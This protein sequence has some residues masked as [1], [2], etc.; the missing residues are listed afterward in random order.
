[1]V[2]RVRTKKTEW[3][4]LSK[5]EQD[6][7]AEEYIARVISGKPSRAAYLRIAKLKGLKPVPNPDRRAR[8]STAK[9]R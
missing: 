3:D 1:M 7:L 5:R 2:T 6:R 9:K 8:R 4:K